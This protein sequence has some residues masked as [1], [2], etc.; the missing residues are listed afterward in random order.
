MPHSPERS[1]RR[2]ASTLLRLLAVTVLAVPAS[3]I[4]MS[5]PAQAATETNFFSGTISAGASASWVWNNANPHSAVYKVGLS[6]VGASTSAVC[7]FEVTNEWY[8]R[9]NTGERKFHFTIKNVGSIACGTNVILSSLGGSTIGSTGG[10][11]PS[12]IMTFSTQLTQVGQVFDMGLIGLLPSGATSSN[13]CRFKVLRTWY[14]RVAQGDVAQPVYLRAEVQNIGN[15]ACSAD[16][17]K[18]VTP[19]ESRLTQRTLNAGSSITTTW[20]NANPTTATH[21]INVEPVEL[22]CTM[23]ITRH[24]YRQVIN[25]NGSAERELI[26]TLKNIGSAQCSARPLLSRI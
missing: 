3:A 5:T 21:V 17:L 2:A 1:S 23:Q 14:Q 24:Y 18:G 13:N 9:L 6:P 11:D 20:N 19:T 25:S 7:A 10:M 12:E 26:L 22:G 16:V 8:E 4:V 15:I